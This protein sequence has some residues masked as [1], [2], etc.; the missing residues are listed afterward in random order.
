MSAALELRPAAVLPEQERPAAQEASRTIARLVGRGRVRVEAK[1]V[2][3][4]EQ[5]QT[6]ILPEPA[7]QMLMD[8]LAQLGTGATV[9]LVPD[10]AEFTTQQAADFLNVSR[11]FVIKLIE[12]GELPHRMVGTHRRILFAELRAYKARLKGTQ[13]RALEAMAADGQA[14]GEYR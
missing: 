4:R 1:P 2:D 6:F 12:R 5:P 14:L 13:R 9:S 11:P 8:L 10:H 3:Q 7:V